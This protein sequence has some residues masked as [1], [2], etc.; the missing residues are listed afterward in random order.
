MSDAIYQA[1]FAAAAVLELPVVVVTLVALA[2][3]IIELGAFVTELVRRRGRRLDRVAAAADRARNELDGGDPD[4]ARRVVEPVAR[5]ESMRSALDAIVQTVGSTPRGTAAEARV[6]KQLADFDFGAQRRLGRT[7]LLVRLGPALGLMG[8]LIP[9]SPAL[10][11]LANGDIDA[12]TENLR[13]AFSVTVLGI[14]IGVVAFAISLVRERLY[15]QDY[16][17]LEYV[18]AVLTSEAVAE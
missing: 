12:L 5:T 2:W 7:R 1:V 4:A 8:T 16:S 6:A 3:T 15:G 14:L 18:A 13:V 17:D 9:L 11:G 10:S